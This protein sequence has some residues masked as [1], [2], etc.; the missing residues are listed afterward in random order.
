MPGQKIIE[1]N[2]DQTHLLRSCIVKFMELAEEEVPEPPEEADTSEIADM[3][4]ENWRGKKEPELGAKAMALVLGCMCGE[5]LRS[6][7]RVDWKCVVDEYGEAMALYGELD[8][9]T[10]LMFP[11]DSA[12]KRIDEPGQTLTEWVFGM[13]EQENVQKFLRPEDEEPKS[14]FQD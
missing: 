10:I 2:E 13:L 4:L 9:E 14:I 11:I 12:Q 1:L 5:L 3:L 7:L 8:G 6:Y